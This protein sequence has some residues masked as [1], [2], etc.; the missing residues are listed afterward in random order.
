[1]GGNGEL[2]HLWAS[3]AYCNLHEFSD[4]DVLWQYTAVRSS[5]CTDVMRNV[6]F[7]VYSEL[8]VNG[9]EPKLLHFWAS[10]AYCNL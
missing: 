10:R 4:L 6:H 3:R 2:L 1:M 5:T 8:D 7:G 9:G